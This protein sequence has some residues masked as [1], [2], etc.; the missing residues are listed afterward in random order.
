MR[1]LSPTCWV[2]QSRV[3]AT[4]SAF[5]LSGGEGVLVDPGITPDELDATHDLIVARAVTLRALVLT[6]A[7][8]DHLLGPV[9][10]PDVPVLTHRAYLDV[11]AAHAHHLRRQVS[12]WQEEEGI[13]PESPFE[14]PMP[15]LA[16]E[17]QVALSFGDHSLRVLAAPGHAPDHCVIYEP[18]NGVLFAGDMLSDLEVPMVMDTFAAYRETL[19]RLAALDLRVLVPGHGTFTRDPAEIRARFGQDQAY[20]EAVSTCAARAVGRGASLT[21]TVALCRPVPFNQPDA[22]PNAHTWNIEQAY[23]EAG[24]QVVA[25]DGPIGW[26]QDWL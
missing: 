12:R 24:G 10:F 19:R 7:H 21:E 6:H 17:K 15:D 9:R 1:L 3:F 8:W 25:A 13:D 4:N 5:F 14:P 23:L 18:E 11:I 20:L 26:E 16:F 2:S 22:Y